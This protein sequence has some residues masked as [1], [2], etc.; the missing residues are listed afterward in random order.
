MARYLR[1]MDPYDH[2]LVVHTYPD[3]QD[4]VYIPLLGEGSP[5]TGASL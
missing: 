4:K 2:R 1:A 5:F 3:Q